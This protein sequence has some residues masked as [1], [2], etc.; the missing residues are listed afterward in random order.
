MENKNESL[1]KGTIAE[2]KNRLI[3]LV[4][5]IRNTKYKEKVVIADIEKVAQMLKNYRWNYSPLSQSFERDGQVLCVERLEMYCRNF[6]KYKEEIYS[7]F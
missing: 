4:L 3:N 6:V 7:L 5:D 1:T 2:I